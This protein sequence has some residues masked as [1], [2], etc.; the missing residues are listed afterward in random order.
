MSSSPWS[1]PGRWAVVTGA[2]SGIGEAFARTLAARGMS[3]VLVARREERLRELAAE[4]RSGYAPGVQAE[5]VAADLGEP[6]APER[7][8]QAATEGRS[9]HL[10]VNNAGFGIAGRL[11]RLPRERQ[12]QMVDLNCRAVLELAHLALG[13]MRERGE[14]GIINVASVAAFQPIPRFATYAASKAFVLSLSEALWDENRRAGVRV[15]ALCPG[16]VPTEFQATAGT[17]RMTATPGLRSAEQVVEAALSALERGRGYVVP[18]GVNR[19]GSILGRLVPLGLATR[20]AGGA[21]R[22]MK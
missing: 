12:A 5:V 22:R 20:I 10:L 1:Y 21:L 13:P 19:L 14:G 4:L 6:G 16:A 11:D 7:A 2:S 8:W 9:I 18:G 17:T 3:T 15:L